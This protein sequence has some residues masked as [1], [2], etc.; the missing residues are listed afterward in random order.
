MLGATA[1]VT[2]LA[3]ADALGLELTGSS[4]GRT[5]GARRVGRAVA[6]GRV[7][8]HSGAEAPARGGWGD[9]SQVQAA[10]LAM[11]WS[12]RPDRPDLAEQ[13]LGAGLEAPAAD[14]AVR[15]AMRIAMV[16]VSLA[17]RDPSSGRLAC[18]RIRDE[19]TLSAA[20]DGC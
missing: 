18:A 8:R 5:R 2:V 10:H 6:R 1:L 13:Q 12:T 17:R 4:H 3:E 20:P 14:G 9:E 7:R 16:H 11:A 15:L 19:I